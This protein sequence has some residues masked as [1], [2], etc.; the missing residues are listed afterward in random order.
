MVLED[1]VNTYDVEIGMTE[2]ALYALDLRNGIRDASG[3]EKLEGVN[4]YRT[5]A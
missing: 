1:R 3:A 4:E 2:K 5:T